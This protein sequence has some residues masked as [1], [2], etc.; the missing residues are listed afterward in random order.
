MS[1]AAWWFAVYFLLVA[2]LLLGVLLV[3]HQ[4]TLIARAEVAR[5]EAE[6]ERDGAVVALGVQLARQAGERAL[7]DLLAAWDEQTA[8][9][10]WDNADEAA[11]AFADF[12]A[13]ETGETI[14]AQQLDGEGVIVA[15][16]N[17]EPEAT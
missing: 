16:P 14:I 10:E 4:R 3:R 13:Q 15:I 2:A 9:V 5:I 12:L 7:R 17:D 11:H 6:R 8:G 1:S